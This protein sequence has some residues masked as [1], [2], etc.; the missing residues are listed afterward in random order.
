MTGTAAHPAVQ[1]LVLQTFQLTP[2]SGDRTPAKDKMFNVVAFVAESAS[3]Q[4]TIERSAS[5]SSKYT[6]VLNPMRHENPRYEP[7]GETS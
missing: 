6:I 7:R 3:K 1:H 2:R 5:Y 4:N